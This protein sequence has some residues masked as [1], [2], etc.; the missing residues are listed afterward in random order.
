MFDGLFPEP[1]NRHIAQ[2]LFALAHWH[3]FAKLR[4]HTELSLAVLDNNTRILGDKLRNFKSKICVKYPARETKKEQQ[5]RLRK[6]KGGDSSKRNTARLPKELNTNTYKWHSLDDYVRQIRMH[7]C[8]DSY[9]TQLVRRCTSCWGHT[10]IESRTNC[11]RKR[12]T[13]DPK[14]DLPALMAKALQNSSRD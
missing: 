6:G 14:D 4:M 7:G 8:T 1:D 12:N 10:L 9:T 11:S 3:G 2:L 13:V 5:A